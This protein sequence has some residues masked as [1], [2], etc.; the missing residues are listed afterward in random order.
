MVKNQRAVRP[1]NRKKSTRTRKKD[2]GGDVELRRGNSSSFVRLR[3]RDVTRP[4]AG[5]NKTRT[6][7]AKSDTVFPFGLPEP[8]RFSDCR[9]EH[10]RTTRTPYT[11]YVRRKKNAIRSGR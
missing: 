8:G 2:R 11:R 9:I 1:G 7:R 3:A 10:V 5:R 6:G 4:I